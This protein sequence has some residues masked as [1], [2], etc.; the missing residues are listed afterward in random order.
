MEPAALHA[1]T[2]DDRRWMK[3]ALKEAERAFD[4]GEVPIG[5]V[6]VRG[7]AEIVGRGFVADGRVDLGGFGDVFSRPRTWRV[8]GQT[9]ALLYLDPA[10]LQH[11]GVLPR[12]ALL[13][14]LSGLLGTDALV[15]TLSPRR[16]KY[17]ERIA[18]ETVRTQV[19]EALRRLKLQP[20]CCSSSCVEKT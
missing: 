20:R 6:V 5:A 13:Q 7:G 2:A 19:G 8:V 16:R 14:R 12:E 11:G 15:R 10:T 9:L 18:A 17:D 3:L 4:A 1:L